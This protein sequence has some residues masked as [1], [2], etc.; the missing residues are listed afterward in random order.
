QKVEP[1]MKDPVGKPGGIGELAVPGSDAKVRRLEF[2]H[3]SETCNAGLFQPCGNPLALGAKNGNQI[4]IGCD[5]TVEGRLG[6]NA[7]GFAMGLDATGVFAS[8]QSI[9]PITHGAVAA[10]E[11]AA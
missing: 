2:E 1:G 5:V 7:L 6:G 3:D 11:I 4:L 8:R 10:H 9:E